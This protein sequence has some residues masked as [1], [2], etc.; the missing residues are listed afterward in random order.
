[1]DDIQ[2]ISLSE[3][4]ILASFGNT[5]DEQVHANIIAL[6][7]ELELTPLQGMLAIVPAY[8]SLAIYYDAAAFEKKEADVSIQAVVLELVKAQI[9]KQK[10]PVSAIKQTII[11]IPVCYDEEYGI[12]LE[13]LS[14]QL[15]LSA[16]EIIQLHTGKTYKVYMMGFT[17]GFA[18]MGTVDEQLFSK[19]KDEPRLKIPAGSVAIAGNQTGIYPLETPG[20]WNII[21]RTAV[22]LFDKEREPPFL[23]K[24]GDTVKFVPVTKEEFESRLTPPSDGVKNTNKLVVHQTGASDKGILIQQCGFLTTL[25]DTGR[26][27]FLQYGVT[28][29][30][31]MDLFSYQTANALLGN[32]LNA[33]TVEI[34]QSPHRFYF[35]KD[36]LAAFTG[37][38][39]QPEANGQIIP[40]FQ[41]VLIPGG[42]VVE[43]KQQIPGFRLYMAVAGGLQADRFL[44]SCSTDL[45]VK[46]GGYSGRALK[47]ED[48]LQINNKLSP[49]QKKLL[50]ILQ[51]KTN[52]TINIQQENFS[53]KI[54]RV[55]K[56]IEWDYL[57][58]SSKQK[59]S[60]SA[61]TIGQQSNRMGYRLKGDALQTVQPC[62]I[63]SSPVTQGTVQLTP[64]GEMIALMADAQTVGGY[65]RI[66]QV[67]AADLSL[68]AQ[69]KPGDEIQFQFIS[70]QEAE[71]L[72]LNRVKEINRIHQMFSSVT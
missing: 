44:N 46:A 63:I 23:L 51:S 31:A 6:K 17:P 7:N 2:F 32:D 60:S 1:M 5:I 21:G 67:C 24:A 43:M 9:K 40:L 72:Y 29:G 68:L 65:P 15:H 56:G 4:A 12:D 58:E 62:E 64:G 59:L 36:I 70:L 30:G 66:M 22:T 52:I 27:G 3:K 33:V 19:R 35:S 13:E 25:Q 45:L 57:S 53:K 47:K 42:T 34:T 28:H 69:K 71:E 20:G 18:Y 55:M 10:A 48:R 14:S 50:H 11:E 49:T 26:T 8:N 38:G 37:G 39:L 41:P 61:F 16:K 54:I